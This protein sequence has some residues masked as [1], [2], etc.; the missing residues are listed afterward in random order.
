MIL[1][2]KNNNLRD[3]VLNKGIKKNSNINIQEKFAL[4]INLE[5]TYVNKFAIISEKFRNIREYTTYE[6]FLLI[7]KNNE[8]YL[9]NSNLSK[10]LNRGENAYS[11]DEIDD[12]IFRLHKMEQNEVSYED[13]QELF[14]P[15]KIFRNETEIY[16]NQPNFE[17]NMN[18]DL[19]QNESSIREHEAESNNNFFLNLKN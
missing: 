11:E 18:S 15:I 2:R 14:T 6:L 16:H 8:K 9:N 7:D 17:L 12:I 3:L 19:N 1:P 4:L 13:F 5:L 10:F